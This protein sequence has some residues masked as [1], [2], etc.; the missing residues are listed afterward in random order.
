MNGTTHQ[1]GLETIAGSAEGGV[2]IDGVFLI[3]LSMN[4]S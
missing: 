2:V 4:A 3:Y 1:T